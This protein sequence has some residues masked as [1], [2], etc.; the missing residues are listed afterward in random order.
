MV[1]GTDFCETGQ[2]LGFRIFMVLIFAV[3]ES[4]GR[5]LASTTAKS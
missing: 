4:G 3:S 5:G 1:G 2:T